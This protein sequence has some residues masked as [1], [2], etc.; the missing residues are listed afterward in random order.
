M[1]DEQSTQDAP[2]KDTSA[3]EPATTTEVETEESQAYEQSQAPEQE[4][5]ETETEGDDA[6]QQG[7]AE[8]SQADDEKSVKQRNDEAAKRRIEEREKKRQEKE[9]LDAE[10]QQ[11]LDQQLQEYVAEGENELAQKVRAM[12][13]ERYR[14]RVANTQESIVNDFERAKLDKD[15]QMFN[16]ESQEFNPKVYDRAVRDYEAGY[17]QV[18][19]YGNIVATKMP[20]LRYLKETA[21]LLSD[22][23]Q[24]GARKGQQAAQKM[25]AVAETPSA[26]SSRGGLDDTDD[27]KLTSQQIAEKYNLKSVRD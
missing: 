20:F 11:Q 7:E 27:S 17:T 15:L 18:D 22:V 25:R 9:Q 1:A 5:E 4:T 24:T 14:E 6:E 2:V 13:V 8:E 19:Q 23:S 16:P 3:D 26:A 21:D 10:R 12:E